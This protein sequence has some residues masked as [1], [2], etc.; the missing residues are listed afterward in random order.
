MRNDAT[1][2]ILKMPGPSTL[3]SWAFHR[4]PSPH[5][6]NQIDDLSGPGKVNLFQLH[7]SEKIQ[8]HEVSKGLKLKLYRNGQFI[9]PAEVI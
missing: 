7:F 6:A 5:L 8:S 2:S 9:S 1:A 3:N 4:L